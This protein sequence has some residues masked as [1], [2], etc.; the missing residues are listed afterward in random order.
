MNLLMVAH[1]YG[2]QGKHA[3]LVKPA[4]DVRSGELTIAS[5][6]GFERIAD[7][8]L[9]PEDVV[10]IDTTK[11]DCILVDE[12]QFLTPLQVDQLRN[13]T[14]FVPVICYGLRTDYQSRLFPGAKRLME[15]ADV[16][17]EIRTECFFCRNKAIMN[18]KFDGDVLVTEGT[19]VPELGGD[20]KYKPGCW[21]CWRHQ[22][23]LS[24]NPP[25]GYPRTLVD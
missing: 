21:S 3:T 20:E 19:S 16:L 5:R 14:C 2:Q 1:S 13:L 6:T 17:E 8:V 4:I 10:V 15:V 24:Q 12:A 22:L 7:V 18:M 23:R 25:V 11:T 9:H